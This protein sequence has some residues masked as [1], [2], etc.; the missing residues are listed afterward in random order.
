MA[1][2]IIERRNNTHRRT[3][4]AKA[5]KQEVHI[6]KPVEPVCVLESLQHHGLE[7]KLCTWYTV[8]G[9]VEM[10]QSKC[11]VVELVKKSL[12]GG[13]SSELPVTASESELANSRVESRALE[14][15]MRGGA[16]FSPY[17]AAA[18]AKS[19]DD[20]LPLSVGKRKH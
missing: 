3:T 7:C 19:V 12:V 10:I 15:E 17:D 1:T 5:R 9:P 8:V 14:S 18:L 2:A 11:P 4:E 6:P 13:Q 16:I 20:V